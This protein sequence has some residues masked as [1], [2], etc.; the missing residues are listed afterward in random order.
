MAGSSTKK[1]IDIRKKSI[2]ARQEGKGLQP[3]NAQ[4]KEEME[5]RE[6]KPKGSCIFH[7]AR[8]KQLPEHMAKLNKLRGNVKCVKARKVMDSDRSGAC[9]QGPSTTHLYPTNIGELGRRLRA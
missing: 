8:V 7:A 2:W 1:P 3:S 9:T 6:H 4:F 5:S